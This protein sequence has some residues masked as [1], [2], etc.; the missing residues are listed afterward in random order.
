MF[1]TMIA[2]LAHFSHCVVLC[3][4]F[5]CYSKSSNSAMD[6][7]NVHSFSLLI[8]R[9][10]CRS[11][12]NAFERKMIHIKWRHMNMNMK[13]GNDSCKVDD[14]YASLLHDKCRAKKCV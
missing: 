10:I 9:Y 11:K 13:Q 1:R 7:G 12:L 4:V 2:T 6:E 5:F 3:N 8:S 14:S